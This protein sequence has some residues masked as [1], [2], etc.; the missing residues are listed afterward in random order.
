MQ[1]KINAD[2]SAAMKSG[3]K[4]L[5]STLKMLK[6]SLD[7]AAKD[8]KG[9]LSQEQA[10]KVL[11]KEKKQR[12]ETA[13]V[14]E[15]VGEEDRAKKERAEAEIISKYLPEEMDEQE[16]KGIVEKAI[17]ENPDMNPGQLMGVIMPQVKG[18]ADGGAVSKMVASVKGQQ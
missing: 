4:D 13:G 1:D 16:L 5:S 18:R 14:Y 2:L 17:Q 9:E 11:S 8:N 15:Q 3:D 6:N 7:N 12:I 10:E